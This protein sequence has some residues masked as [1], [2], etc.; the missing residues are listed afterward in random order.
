MGK[1]FL[2]RGRTPPT[3]TTSPNCLSIIFLAHANC[4]K[5]Y[6][7]DPNITGVQTL[8]GHD[9]HLHIQMIS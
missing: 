6:F 1:I 5:I 2:L 4:S 3:V 8:P 7:N 9:N